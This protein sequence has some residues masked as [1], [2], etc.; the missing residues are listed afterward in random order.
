M[1]KNEHERISHW[2][3]G[4]SALGWSTTDGKHLWGR[5][6][7]YNRL[8]VETRVCCVPRGTSYTTCTSATEHGVA[9]GPRYTAAYAAAGTGLSILP[10]C[11]ILYE[12]INEK[13]LMGGQLYYR[14]FAHY[15]DVARSGTDTLQPPLAVYHLL[16][17]CSCVE[18]VVRT[19][20]QDVTLTSVPLF[21]AV[22]P[23]HWAFSD[24]SGEM[25]ILEPDESGLSIYRNTIGVMTNS[26]SYSW[27]R[28]NLLNYAAI[29]DLDYDTVEVCGEKLEQCF[30][31]SGAQG[32]PGDWSSPSRF[33]R[34][35]LLK[36]HA[37]RGEDEVQ[38]ITNLFHLLGSV[39]FPLGM[40]RVTDQGSTSS[41]DKTGMPFDYTIYTAAMCAE[42]LRFYW[43]THENQRIQY[44]DLNDLAA[45]GKACQFDLGRRA[46][47]Q[48]CTTPKRPTESVL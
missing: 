37:V 34:L 47:Y 32:L 30:S 46:D 10:D 12:G 28:L 9:R 41:L 3:A 33:I 39:A 2:P 31:G 22:P 40:V 20:Q 19:L 25:V 11:P 8:A 23:L 36:Q 14:Q 29:R 17:Q 16:A 4:C 13:G 26:P 18:E 43:T 27:H 48:P 7:D 44:I 42:S 5:N 38:G 35:A 21:G 15:P 1:Q 24:R 45:S 6:L